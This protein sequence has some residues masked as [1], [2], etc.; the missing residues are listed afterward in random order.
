MTYEEC[1]QLVGAYAASVELCGRLEGDGRRA[2]AA[3]VRDC[4]GEFIGSLLETSAV[5]DRRGL[6]TC[7]CCRGDGD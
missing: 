3:T 5:G 4:L 1:M 6:V 7:A 2:D